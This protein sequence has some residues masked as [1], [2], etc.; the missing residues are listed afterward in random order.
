MSTTNTSQFVLQPGAIAR[1]D[2]DI[3]AAVLMWMLIEQENV[4][5]AAKMS[6]TGIQIA[7]TSADNLQTALQTEADAMRNQA[8]GAIAGACAGLLGAAAG[9]ISLLKAHLFDGPELDKV[10]KDAD[11]FKNRLGTNA[12]EIEMRSDSPRVSRA[13]EE[14]NPEFQTQIL[15]DKATE[16]YRVDPRKLSSS[17]KQTEQARKKI[18]DF[19]SQKQRERA[20][21]P[22]KA[23]T[24]NQWI[25]NLSQGLGSGAQAGANLKAAGQQR[26]A[27]TNRALQ[28]LQQTI[29][30]QC[31][32]GSDRLMELLRSYQSGEEGLQSLLSRVAPTA[33][34]A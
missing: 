8:F 7:K 27:A 9:G 24:H 1:V 3:L 10:I 16:F 12:P 5:L 32:S 18:E 17:T 33:A 26:D 14:D 23:S 19:L 2:G 4:R 28:T 31:K 6:N 15:D 30:E 34:G 22:N 29:S 25:Q 21:L 11:I 20:D 13:L